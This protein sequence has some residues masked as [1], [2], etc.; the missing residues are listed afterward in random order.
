MK[1]FDRQGKEKEKWLREDVSVTY[2]ILSGM[3]KGEQQKILSYILYHISYI[4]Y[5]ILFQTKTQAA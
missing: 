1:P 3:R 2:K 4:L 5:P